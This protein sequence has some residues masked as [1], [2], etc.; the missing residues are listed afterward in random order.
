MC[1]H[2]LQIREIGYS[3]TTL[4]QTT[5]KLRLFKTKGNYT[6]EITNNY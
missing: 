3:Q 5:G 6:F 2:G 1:T 4:K